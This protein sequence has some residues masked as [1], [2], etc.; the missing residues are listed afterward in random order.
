LNSFLFSFPFSFVLFI[1]SAS[2]SHSLP[3]LL[4]SSLDSVRPFA[5]CSHR[6]TWCL[7]AISTVCLSGELTKDWSRHILLNAILKRFHFLKMFPL[8]EQSAWHLVLWVFCQWYDQY[9]KFCINSE[10]LKIQKEKG[11]TKHC[12]ARKLMENWESADVSVPVTGMSVRMQRVLVASLWK[13]SQFS[14]QDNFCLFRYGF[15][16]AAWRQN[17]Y[18][19]IK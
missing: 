6:C 3:C 11:G 4:I 17:R 5:Y 15:V 7:Y 2:I 14:A 12:K 10:I 18:S 13:W 8:L 9:T 16:Y 1:R 19:T